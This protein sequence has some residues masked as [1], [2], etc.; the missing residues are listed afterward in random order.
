MIEEKRKE[1]EKH[2]KKLDSLWNEIPK[3]KKEFN[4]ARPIIERHIDEFNRHSRSKMDLKRFKVP[5]ENV[6]FKVM[7]KIA[8]EN[9]NFDKAEFLE[10]FRKV[11]KYV[12]HLNK[13][14]KATRKMVKL[15]E[16]LKHKPQA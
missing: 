14:D 12:E 13:I 11:R 1:L 15:E 3:L 10:A 4:S 5:S 9:P 2:R 6:V 7:D 8:R 16:E